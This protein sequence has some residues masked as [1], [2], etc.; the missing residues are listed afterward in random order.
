MPE[1]MDRHSDWGRD[2]DSL[3]ILPR[4]Q[5]LC[6][7]FFAYC[8]EILFG[9]Q[10]SCHRFSQWM[11][12]N[13]CVVANSA[14]V[15]NHFSLEWYTR[16]WMQWQ[17]NFLYA[18][19]TVSLIYSS[20]HVRPRL[21]CTP[22]I[23]PTLFIAK[24]NPFRP[25]TYFMAQSKVETRKNVFFVYSFL[26]ILFICKFNFVSRS[27]ERAPLC[28]GLGSERIYLWECLHAHQAFL[29]HFRLNGG[30]KKKNVVKKRK[31][32]KNCYRLPKGAKI[33][34]DFDVDISPAQVVHETTMWSQ[35][36]ECARFLVHWNRSP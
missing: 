3:F 23:L 27:L 18:I 16:K 5:Q 11:M 33:S 6:Q 4:A 10:L 22:P 31:D 14:S 24:R 20:I 29:Q 32:K 8:V 30:E 2:W 12:L 19:V 25:L 1:E 34:P 13:E 17:E 28:V 15:W 7:L 21:A 36:N 9:W 35:R 26:S